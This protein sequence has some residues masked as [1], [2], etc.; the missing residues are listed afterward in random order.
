MDFGPQ[1][2][3]W[4]Q[5][6]LGLAVTALLVRG[7]WRHARPVRHSSAAVLG[8]LCWV[9]VAAMP[10]FLEETYCRAAAVSLPGCD[11]EYHRAPTEWWTLFQLIVLGGVVQGF[12]IGGPLAVMGFVV[13]IVLRSG[14]VPEGTASGADR[15]RIDTG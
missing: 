10:G 4:L 9:A 11:W 8:L 12:R 6:T 15:P 5:L 3:F 14:R 7:A 2:P 1:W 13:G